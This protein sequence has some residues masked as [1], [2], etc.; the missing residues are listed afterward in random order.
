MTNP[1]GTLKSPVWRSL[2]ELQLYTSHELMLDKLW[3]WTQF[4]QPFAH[5]SLPQFDLIGTLSIC[6]GTR[7]TLY[8]P[9]A[10]D[11]M[12]MPGTFRILLLR[13]LSLVQTM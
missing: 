11:M 7:S 5:L 8:I 12:G 3:A 9:R 4:H 13:S 10:T 6:S 1:T 2:E